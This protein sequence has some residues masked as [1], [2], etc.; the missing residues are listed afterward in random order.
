M[1][2]LQFDA[3]V[4]SVSRMRFTWL[5][6]KFSEFPPMRISTWPTEVYRD[7][8]ELLRTETRGSLRYN[9]CPLGVRHLASEEL[10]R[11][12]PTVVRCAVVAVSFLVLIGCGGGGGNSTAGPPPPPA[13]FTLSLN[14]ASIALAQS[15]TQTVQVKT[16]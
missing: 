1:Q 12:F 7:G 8:F 3:G 5:W 4:R 11:V 10:E 2:I 16:M 15:G 6:L 9:A 13:T 14:P